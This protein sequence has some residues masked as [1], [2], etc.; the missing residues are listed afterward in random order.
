MDFTYHLD[1]ACCIEVYV[2]KMNS[3]V[4]VSGDENELEWLNVTDNFFDMRRFAGE[5]NIGLYLRNHDAA[6][7][8][9]AMGQPR[10]GRDTVQP[11]FQRLQKRRDKLHA[12]T[13]HLGLRQ[14]E[15]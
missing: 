7:I 14:V 2:G 15:A 9:L 12:N 6:V 4:K 10:H 8:L 3:M 1:D 13:R 5:G 11:D